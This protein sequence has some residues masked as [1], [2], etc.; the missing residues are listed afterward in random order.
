MGSIDAVS[1]GFGIGDPL[2]SGTQR[3]AG[4]VMGGMLPALAYVSQSQTWGPVPAAPASDTLDL[5]ATNLAS[6]TI[7]PKRAHV[8]CNARVNV[9]TDG[10]VT[11]TLAGCGRAITAG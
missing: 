9:K 5:N 11:I 2:P 3:G 7:D 8:D 4:T 10:P 6:A 1:R